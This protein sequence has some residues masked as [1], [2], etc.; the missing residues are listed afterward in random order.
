M[1]RLPPQQFPEAVQV[2][3]FDVSPDGIYQTWQSPDGSAWDAEQ[4]DVA[5]NDGEAEMGLDWNRLEALAANAQVLEKPT[6]KKENSDFDPVGVAALAMGLGC[7]GR[8]HAV[9]LPVSI[10]LVAGVNPSILATETAVTVRSA[11]NGVLGRMYEAPAERQQRADMVNAERRRRAVEVS[12]AVPRPWATEQANIL[13]GSWAEAAQKKNILGDTYKN[14]CGVS[15]VDKRLSASQNDDACTDTPTIN[16]SIGRPLSKR[17]EMQRRIDEVGKRH[18]EHDKHETKDGVPTNVETKDHKEI[19]S[20]GL[21][22]SEVLFAQVTTNPGIPPGDDGLCPLCDMIAR[23][24]SKPVR[25][26][27]HTYATGCRRARR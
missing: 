12:R 7:R 4:L 10:Q 6:E 20:Q 26:G 23:G 5:N 18:V 13:G 3:D 2:N 15:E 21:A 24:A 9:H 22:G 8:N 25:K 17:E 19:N 14:N 16:D 1:Y 11:A 27:G